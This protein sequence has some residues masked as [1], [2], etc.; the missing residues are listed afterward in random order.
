MKNP[1][2]T[3]DQVQTDEGPLRLAQRGES[4]FLITIDGRVLMAGATHR[5]EALLATATAARLQ[6]NPAP[7]ILVGG[8][9]MGLT[10]RTALDHLPRGA[11][12]TVVELNPVVVDWCR[13]PLKALTEAAVE[14]PRVTVRIAD[15]AQVIREAARTRETYD[16]IVLDLYEG[17]HETLGAAGA[18]FYGRQA[19][20][21]TRTA[22]A[23]G[24]VFAVW[25][26]QADPPFEQRL[27]AQGFTV[28]RLAPERGGSRHVV[29][30]ATPDAPRRR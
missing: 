23:P 14:D 4:E 28:Q 25:S 18:P 21:T 24:G 5:S 6:G 15:V 1:W 26:E 2:R 19:L 17:P 11:R 12:L 30:L 13:G 29:Y 22:L 16:A 10:L 9:G 8:L 3:L 20:Q 7:K 27:K